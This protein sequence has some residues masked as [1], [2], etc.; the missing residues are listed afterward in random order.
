MLTVTLTVNAQEYLFKGIKSGMSESQY[1]A[2]LDTQ[3]SFDWYK[4]AVYFC[5]IENR[6]YLV[7]PIFNKYDKLWGLSISCSENFEWFDYDPNCIKIMEELYTLLKT[8][9]GEPDYNKKKSWSD[10]P[11]NG[12]VIIVE[13]K[14]G[15]L[16]IGINASET[17]EKY[18]VWVSIIDNN[19]YIEEKTTGGF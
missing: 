19:F 1:T 7:L 11:K 4:E 6:L 13:W 8:K 9:Y 14:Y 2:F 16:D 18:N 17:N 10:I 12:N 5:K 15:T 3:E